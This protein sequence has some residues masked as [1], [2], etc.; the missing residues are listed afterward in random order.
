MKK[1]SVF[2]YI[3]HT[4]NKQIN[5]LKLINFITYEVDLI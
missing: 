3:F 2:L 4:L 5:K 1:G